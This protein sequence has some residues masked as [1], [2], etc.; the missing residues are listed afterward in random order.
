M[1]VD[2]QVG[3]IAFCQEAPTPPPDPKCHVM[4]MNG[5]HNLDDAIAFDL[6]EL[7]HNKAA[8][9]DENYHPIVFLD[10]GASAKTPVKGLMAL[11]GD[12]QAPVYTGVRYIEKDFKT[13]SMKVVQEL[14]EQNSDGPT[15][16]TKFLTWAFGRC[17]AKSP[18]A[19]ILLS[20]S[21]H[22]NGW[23]GFGGD[24][25]GSSL[26]E[27]G[28]A[29]AA[30]GAAKSGVA[31][32]RNNQ[33][34]TAILDS[35]AAVVPPITEKLDLLAFDACFMMTYASLYIFSDVAELY[36]ASEAT[37]PGHGW[38]YYEGIL[39]SLSTSGMAKAIVDVFAQSMQGQE[40]QQPK[41]LAFIH[42]ED[43]EAFKVAMDTLA[44]EM[45]G[46]LKGSDGSLA[47]GLINSAW[48]QA[49]RPNPNDRPD[50]VDLGDFL[51][52]LRLQD[53]PSLK[54]AIAAAEAKYS[55]LF[56]RGHYAMGPNTDTS[57]TGM[58]IWLPGYKLRSIGEA[59]LV[60]QWKTGE[61]GFAAAGSRPWQKFLDAR[62]E[63][64][65]DGPCQSLPYATTGPAA[66]FCVCDPPTD[67]LMDVDPQVGN[68]A[69]CQEAP[70][71]T[72][73]PDQWGDDAGPSY[74][75]ILV[76]LGG[77]C[78][79]R[80]SILS[81]NVENMMACAALASGVGVKAFSLGKGIQ[82]GRCY[83]ETLAVD[84]ALK[85]KWDADRANPPCPAKDGWQDDKT[86]DFYYLEEEEA[87]L[88]GEGHKQRKK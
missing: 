75:G 6:M 35:K 33:I 78:G 10:R 87:L 58:A 13:S 30:Q 55:D 7:I 76:K 52:K 65:V 51:A 24:E 64:M 12:Q 25:A 20:L 36:L 84:D 73:D 59:A 54:D 48:V 8:M 11:D 56:A 4:Y 9:T 29:T 47:E 38:N 43:F 26:L 21:S 1:D 71:T 86:T 31:L 41:T 28:Q 3:N 72:P 18:D 45:E 39:P 19:K 62:D 49:A 44:G 60:K 16:M 37:E 40:H 63:F 42:A 85:K 66:E 15:V 34:R 81:S 67:K 88:Q 57:L 82:A 23:M 83:A 69:F 50:L 14:A 46:A 70:T 53:A 68:I 5:D 32:I 77:T 2:P 61:G 27:F 22:G 80:G 79:K 17:K 74:T